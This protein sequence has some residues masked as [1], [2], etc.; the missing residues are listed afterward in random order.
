MSTLMRQNSFRLWVCEVPN[1]THLLL[2][3]FCFYQGK[4]QAKS[5]YTGHIGYK[6]K[7]CETK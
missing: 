3:Q 4:L 2:P 6:K 5:N 1:W 7:S